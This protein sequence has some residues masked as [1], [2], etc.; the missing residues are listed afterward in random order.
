MN[1]TLS[2]D[3][4]TDHL[5]I[6]DVH[7][8]ALVIRQRYQTPYTQKKT[9]DTPA[10]LITPLV[11]PTPV[12][13]QPQFYVPSA[14]SF[15]LLLHHTYEAATNH[16]SFR[17]LEQHA[18]QLEFVTFGL[19][20]WLYRLLTVSDSVTP[21]HHHVKMY[22]ESLQ[23]YFINIEIPDFLALPLSHMGRFRHE[24]MN[25]DI[26]A[27]FPPIDATPANRHNG[28][29]N[30]ETSHC[31]PNFHALFRAIHHQ[32]NGRTWNI[33]F[34][35]GTAAAA[36][37]PAATIQTEYYKLPGLTTPPR[38]PTRSRT[39]L[40]HT[41]VPS[42]PATSLTT[43]VFQL[44]P[45]PTAWLQNMLT[46]WNSFCQYTAVRVPLKDMSTTA[47]SNAA[48]IIVT[49]VAN[50]DTPGAADDRWHIT[51]SMC[52]PLTGIPLAI[53]TGLFSHY[54]PSAAYLYNG[55]TA[56][57]PGSP[58]LSIHFPVQSYHRTIEVFPIQQMSQYCT[59][60]ITR[61]PPK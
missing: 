13:R 45:L 56:V 7:Y 37:A 52:E 4:T 19:Y 18:T 43:N 47:E 50:I 53:G 38:P 11:T 59:L 1:N 26:Y 16:K 27:A 32:L 17:F 33:N 8:E 51:A 44:F 29:W 34:Q 9:M 36:P 49:D 42:M 15:A 39:T 31:L 41:N 48:I 21:L 23:G 25:C 10:L 60:N 46:T 20:L 2:S 22:L 30:N 54:H 6:R 55:A 58:A 40:G 14:H 24:Y 57:A 61:T 3:Q 12:I 28:I 5:G 35:D